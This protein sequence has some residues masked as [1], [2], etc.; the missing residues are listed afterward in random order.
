MKLCLFARGSPTRG[1][2][3]KRLR[4]WT[5]E[6]LSTVAK[7]Y[8]LFL[9]VEKCVILVLRPRPPIIRWEEVNNMQDLHSLVL[10]V[11]ADVISYCICNVL[12]RWLKGRKH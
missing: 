9:F 4:G 8:F 7:R 6:G 12:D 1:A 11:A 2:G 10:S 5:K 3:A